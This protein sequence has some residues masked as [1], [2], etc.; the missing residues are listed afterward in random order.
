MIGTWLGIYFG[1]VVSDPKRF[2]LD[3]VM[4]CF[5]LTMVVN[6]EKNLRMLF[7]WSV[8][9]ISSLLA[10]R[11]LPENSHIIVGAIAGG[12]AGLAWGYQGH[13]R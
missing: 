5:L 3:M 1:N 6:G 2:G 9:A 8:A 4:G 7:I 11:F 10:Y 12:L 13:A